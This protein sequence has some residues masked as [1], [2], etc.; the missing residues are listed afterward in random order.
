VTAERPHA[1]PKTNSS[2]GARALRTTSASPQLIPRADTASRP[3]CS[4]HGERPEHYPGIGVLGRQ[5]ACGGVLLRPAGGASRQRGH[6]ERA[7][8]PAARRGRRDHRRLGRQ[9]HRP[10]VRLSRRAV[11]RRLRG[12]LSQA[13]RPG[14]FDLARPRP[15]QLAEAHRG[16]VRALGPMAAPSCASRLWN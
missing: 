3:G 5:H 16:H 4:A 8:A 1:P 14:R 7:P 9:L 2:G 15:V 11:V 10:L 13:R 12:T 6:R